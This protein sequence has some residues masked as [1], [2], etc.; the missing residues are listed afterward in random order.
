VVI[1]ER[2]KKREERFFCA[3]Q[4]QSP[5]TCKKKKGPL[6][7]R[8]FTIGIE[9]YYYKLLIFYRLMRDFLLFDISKG[10]GA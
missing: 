2:S 8:S 5:K 10:I 4:G 9:N 3:F 6:E 1:E 7:K